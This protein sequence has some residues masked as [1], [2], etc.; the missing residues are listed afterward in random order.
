MKII[1]ISKIIGIFAV[2]ILISSTT[3]AQKEFKVMAE[4]SITYAN[5]KTVYK[6]IGIPLYEDE[7]KGYACGKVSDYE[8]SL[9]IASEIG[10]RLDDG[11]V[12]LDWNG[13]ENSSIKFEYKEKF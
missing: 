9:K 7:C 5:G 11:K 4:C 2:L 10:I 8:I 1:N 6:C 13:N 12:E 3:F